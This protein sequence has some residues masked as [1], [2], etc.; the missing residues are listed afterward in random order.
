MPKPWQLN[1]SASTFVWLLLLNLH[2][3][4]QLPECL[5]FSHPRFVKMHIGKHN[6]LFNLYSVS[7]CF[8]H[9]NCLLIAMWVF[10][11]YLRH[12]AASCVKADVQQTFVTLFWQNLSSKALI[13]VLFF[14][15]KWWLSSGKLTCVFHPTVRQ[16]D[17]GG[18]GWVFLSLSLILV[19][20]ICYWKSFQF[21]F[22][23]WPHHTHF[24]SHI[25][26]NSFKSFTM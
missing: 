17:W 23:L 19:Q 8:V 22:I 24:W 13:S 3:L 7:S 18:L 9:F 5:Q 15:L 20:V 16:G 11:L 21:F 26:W 25:S 1:K 10:F 14:R 12:H 2:K 4:L 6:L